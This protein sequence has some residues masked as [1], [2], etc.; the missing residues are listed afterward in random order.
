M[1]WSRSRRPTR[2]HANRGL[3]SPPAHDR[4]A[5][6]LVQSASTVGESDGGFGVRIEEAAIRGGQPVEHRV[7][8]RHRRQRDIHTVGATGA[9]QPVGQHQRRFGLAAAGLVLDQEQR[10]AVREFHVAGPRLH[11]A[12][13]GV[14]ADQVGPR[15][16]GAP[17]S[18]E[19]ARLGDG[20]FRPFACNAPIGSEVLLGFG[21]RKPVLTRPDP[22][23]QHRETGD[24]V[25]CAPPRCPA[26]P[27][28]V[29]HRGEKRARLPDELV[30]GLDPDPSELA[31]QRG[32][33]LVAAR[34]RRR[35]MVPGDRRDQRAPN[36][37][38]DPLRQPE[39]GG[40]HVEQGQASCTVVVPAREPRRI[41]AEA[42][43][44]AGRLLGLELPGELAHVVEAQQVADQR[45]RQLVRQPQ[46]T[47]QALT[48]S[49]VLREQ[50]LADRGHVQAVESR[51]VPARTRRPRG[52]ALPQN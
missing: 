8:R 44:V 52:R 10:R 25:R 40:I 36:R 46:Q 34:R 28:Q 6:T 37:M 15:E 13:R 17:G 20:A 2:A 11:G 43:R 24:R 51:R 32:P 14:G 48:Q 1:P 41:V 23:R 19:H 35:A 22:V 38:T 18:R 39:R 42:V 27:R 29:R 21:V 5:E 26:G 50:R 16:P 33:A 30:G 3:E 4:R 47:A 7:R 45:S 49:A 12:R 31:S 9:H